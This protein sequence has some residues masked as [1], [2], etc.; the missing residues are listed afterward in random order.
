MIRALVLLCL[1]ALPVAAQ[2]FRGLMPGMAAGERGRLGEPLAI[3]PPDEA[4]LIRAVYPLPFDQRLEVY[5]DTRRILALG[6]WTLPFGAGFGGRPATGG[7]RSFTATIADVTRMAGS[8]GYIYQPRGQYYHE[9]TDTLWWMVYPLADNPDVM[10]ELRFFD[11][12]TPRTLPMLN[13]DTVALPGD[14]QM[15]RATLYHRDVIPAI[16]G[17]MAATLIPRPGAAP[18]A[19]PIAEAFPLTDLP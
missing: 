10:L 17:D 5:H 9:G 3:A 14:V 4:G 16:L 11:S 19:L 18:F 2:D 7:L 8:E 13:A 15:T 1:L 6:T 12:E